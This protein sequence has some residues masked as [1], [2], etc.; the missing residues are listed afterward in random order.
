MGSALHK[1]LTNMITPAVL[2]AQMNLTL[3]LIT[4]SVPDCTTSLFFLETCYDIAT[5][6]SFST[7][8]DHS[9]LLAKPSIWNC[10]TGFP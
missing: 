2:D 8:L 4:M 9:G 5:K 7:R 3:S 1:D 10:G 6:K